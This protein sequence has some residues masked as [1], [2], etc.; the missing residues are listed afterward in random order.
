MRVS[1]SG[2]IALAAAYA[3]A[4]WVALQ[5]AVPPY[6]VSQVFPPAGIAL[7]AM[8]IFGTG[9]WPGGAAGAAMVQLLASEDAGVHSLA[10]LAAAPVGATAQ[11]LFGYWLAQRLIGFPNPLDAGRSI[12]LFLLVVA[13]VSCL[14]SASVAVPALMF[15]GVIGLPDAFFS[16][17]NWWLGDSLGVMVAAP[18]MFVLFGRPRPVWRPRLF[19]VALPLLVTLALTMFA[20]QGIRDSEQRRIEQQFGRE[21]EGVAT[22]TAKRLDAQIDMIVAI[23]RLVGHDPAHTAAEF[24]RFVLPMLDRH[25]GTQNFTWNPSVRADERAEFERAVSQSIPGYRVLDRLT[26]AAVRVAPAAEAE[27]YFP[28]LHV[29]PREGNR[30]VLGLNP[31]SF[32]PAREAIAAALTEGRPIASE[33]FLLTQERAAQ[34][35]VVIYHA[36]SGVAGGQPGLVSGAFRMDDLMDAV[37]GD[38]LARSLRACLM[39]RDAAP[40]N[41]R[42]TG[43]DI[44]GAEAPETGPLSSTFPIAF[45]GRQW[46][47]RVVAD[48]AFLRERRTWVAYA[49]LTFGLFST[50]LLGAFLLM[51]SGQARRIGTLVEQRTAELARTTWSLRDQQDALA[52]AQRIAHLGSWEQE[53]ED[54]LLRC[55][56]GLRALVPLPDMERFELRH[57]LAAFE[58][59]DARRL[60]EA[61][62]RLHTTPDAVE[63][64]CGLRNPGASSIVHVVVEGEWKGGR[65][66]RV[67]GT[68]QDVTEARRAE[69]DIQR[70]AHYDGLTGLLNRNLWAMRARSALDIAQRHGDCLAVLFLDLDQFKTVNDSLGHRV[71]DG[72][73]AETGHRLQSC[74]RKEDLLARLGGDEFVALLPRLARPHDA[75]TVA[76]KMLD[77]LARP[78]VVDGHELT[79]SAS[80]GIAVHPADGADVDTLLQHADTAMYSAKDAGRNTFQFFVQEMNVRVLRRLRV[81]SG[82]RR[83]LD[84]NEFT[85]HFQPQFDAET[86]VLVGVEALLR[87]QHPEHGSMLPGEFIPVAEESGLIIPIGDWVMRTVFKQQARWREQGHRHLSVAVNISALQFARP[88]FA[89]KVARIIAETGADPSRI[90]LEITESALMDGSPSLSRRLQTLTGMGLK[91]A[92]DD[93]GTGY[94]SLAYLKR[95]PLDRLKLDRSFVRDLPDDPDDAAIALAAISVA[96][97]LGMQ[98]IAEGV[99]TP[100]QREFLIAHGCRWMQGFLFSEPLP[101]QAFD[102]CYPPPPESG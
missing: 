79:L 29:E 57:L 74:M 31:A 91:L 58:P 38:S 83:A 53:A 23:E 9:V 47:L 28:I 89:D 59:G 15:S 52:R 69:T 55:S 90:E 100:G 50:G 27:V 66:Q 101:V 14:V 75:G 72:L 43:P 94:S 2:S 1:V 77:V 46:E 65:L 96:R 11:A 34:R 86:L 95:L 33:P 8:L 73:L 45:A 64:D 7:S 30:G 32:S 3:I 49:T 26:D 41:R 97:D 25:P 61:I 4:G 16:W 35:G 60:K 22:L 76:R 82:L 56:D 42:L 67:L 13:P 20:F 62:E 68:A 18:L 85:M 99:E 92:L 88:D 54:G 51:T 102:R 78:M 17:W 63:L 12:T 87:W 40:G 80:V 93:F 81:G 98:V 44:C 70:L 71:G 36:V 48:D 37:I 5:V 21:A 84:R 6:S 39:D 19:T 10:I 24:R